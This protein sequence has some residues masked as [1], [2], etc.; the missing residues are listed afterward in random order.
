[1][2]AFLEVIS[3]ENFCQKILFKNLKSLCKWLHTARFSVDTVGL[4]GRKF[5]C[6]G[7]GTAKVLWVGNGLG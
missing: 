3:E 2:L 4:K 1:M 6:N 7:S 5:V